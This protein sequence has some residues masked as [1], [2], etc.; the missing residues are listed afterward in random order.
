M[1]AVSRLITICCDIIANESNIITIVC[2][3]GAMSRIIAII[4]AA[5]FVFMPTLFFYAS[6]LT[7]FFNASCQSV[8]FMLTLLFFMLA[9][10]ADFMLTLFILC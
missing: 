6:G 7:L 9:S 10:Q 3:I 5:C 1:I 2:K 4:W 8:F